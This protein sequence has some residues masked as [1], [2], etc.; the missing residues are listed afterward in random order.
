MASITPTKVD[1]PLADLGLDGNGLLQNRRQWIKDCLQ[2]FERTKPLR[3]LIGSNS[4][5]CG[6]AEHQIMRLIPHLKELGLEV[7]HI[8]YS[9]PHFLRDRFEERN[10]N[11]NFFDRDSM[12]QWR[13]WRRTMSFIRQKSFDVAHAFN[14]TANFYV[15]GAAAL[16]GVPVLIGGWR[17]RPMGGGVKFRLPLSLLNMIS[18]AW[19]VNAT[20]NTEALENLWGIHKL[21]TYVVPNALDFSE[22]DYTVADPLEEEIL[23]WINGRVIVGAVGTISKQKNFDLFLDVAKRLGHRSSETCFC[24]IGGPEAR[25]HDLQ[26]HLQQR[27]EREGLSEYVCMLGNSENVAGF[28]PHFSV[29][30]CT[31]DFEGC[32]NVVMEAM[33]ARLAVVMTD[34]CDTDLLIEE[35]CN[36]HVVP[37]G[38][39]DSLACSTAE[40]LDDPQKRQQFGLRGRELAEQN[41]MATE[42]AWL[43]ARI[44]L[45]E[46]KR[47]QQEPRGIY[48]RLRRAYRK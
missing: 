48:G 11:T 47:F 32:P 19:V 34:C 13:F 35:N 16:A 22:R 30:L 18:N 20:T 45:T 25:S 31:S 43:M 4:L 38:S 15:R 6:G 7:E 1:E 37:V 26:R 42:S 14:G 3:V 17:N 46:W 24:L 27:I 40:L 23:S 10:L 44:Y 41:F 28:L 36:G 2:D 29:L 39:V 5:G 12:G 21:P 8:Y 33:R 9:P